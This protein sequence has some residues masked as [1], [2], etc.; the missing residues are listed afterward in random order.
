MNRAQKALAKFREQ[1]IRS[2]AQAEYDRTV[3][4][5]KAEMNIAAMNREI[6]FLQNELSSNNITEKDERFTDGKKPKFM[7]LNQIDFL[8]MNLSNQQEQVDIIKKENAKTA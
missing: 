4:L 1:S 6:E 2:Q 8:K 5:R 7:I 3:S